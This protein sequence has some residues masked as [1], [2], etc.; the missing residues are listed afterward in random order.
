[1]HPACSMATIFPLLC[2]L[3][4]LWVAVKIISN[5][6]AR[7][8][9]TAT[10]NPISVAIT[11]HSQKRL[12]CG[13]CTNA[14]T[15]LGNLTRKPCWSIK[16]NTRPHSTTSLVLMLCGDVQSNPGPRRSRG[17][18]RAN[19]RPCSASLHSFYPCGYCQEPVNWSTP[20]VCCGSCNVWFHAPCVDLSQSAYSLLGHESHTWHCYRCNTHNNLTVYHQYNIVTRNSFAALSLSDTD[21]V[22]DAL[23]SPGPPGTLDARAPAP[24][25]KGSTRPNLP[26]TSPGREPVGPLVSTLLLQY[27]VAQAHTCRLIIVQRPASYHQSHPAYQPWA[28]WLAHQSV[29][30]CRHRVMGQ[31]RAAVVTAVHNEWSP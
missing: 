17:S 29:T 7:Q 10:Y 26:R 28:L 21:N 18:S 14:G 23:A 25:P 9:P 24:Q 20:G 15:L 4:C 1:M 13:L 12:L 5:F 16:Q 22:F 11:D 8:L 6:Y 2:L 31:P 27:T 3:L 30:I 19:P